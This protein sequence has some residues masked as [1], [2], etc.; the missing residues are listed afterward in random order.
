MCLDASHLQDLQ[1]FAKEIGLDV[2]V[3]VHDADEA[4]IALR[5]EADLTGVN[6]RNL[7]TFDVNFE[8]TFE[9]LPAL[10]GNDRVVVS[11]SGISNSLS[12]QKKNS[13]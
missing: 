13:F 11:E 5:A 9:L 8:T 6:N 1:G 10:L 7:N 2:L 12:L 3:E 4:A